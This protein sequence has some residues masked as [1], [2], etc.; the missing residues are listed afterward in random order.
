MLELDWPVQLAAAREATRARTLTVL[1]HSLGGQLAA[2]YLAL[3]PAAF[4]RLVT[5][6]SCSVD[7]RGWPVPERY[8]ILAATQA[9]GIIGQTLGYFPGERLGFGGRQSRGVV[10]D[11]SHNARTGLYDPHRA[12]LDFESALRSVTTDALMISI[13]GDSLAPPGAVDLLARKLPRARVVREHLPPS[14][15]VEKKNDPHFKWA[16][17]P[18]AL[19]KRVGEYLRE[20]ERAE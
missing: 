15:K 16:R 4:S 1:G 18:G 14:W 3:E 20:T 8:R 7:F 2:L 9:V 11:W 5:I 6:A 10:R 17:E 19:P 13:E 12:P